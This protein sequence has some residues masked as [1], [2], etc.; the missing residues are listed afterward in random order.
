MLK[1]LIIEYIPHGPFENKYY[2]I[3]RNTKLEI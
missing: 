1:S 2:F 3:K